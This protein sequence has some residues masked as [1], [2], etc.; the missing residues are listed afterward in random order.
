VFDDS[1]WHQATAF[2][3]NGD[4]PWGDIGL[5]VL[6]LPAPVHLRRTFTADKPVR[7]A[8]ALVSAMGICQVSINGR[9][10]GEDYFVP[11][12]TD[13]TKRIYY[14]QYDVT[15]RIRRGENVF[16]GVLADGWFSGYIGWGYRRGHYGRDIRLAVQLHLEYDDGSTA[17]IVT[18]GDWK[19]ATGPTLEADFLMGETYDARREMVGWD[20][21]GFDDSG[22]AKA[23]TGSVLKPK[24]EAYPGHTVQVF[25]EIAPVSI[26]EPVKG[27]Y[28]FD[29]GTNLAGAA[30]LKVRGKRGDT[31]VLRYAERL[32]PDGTIYTE[33]LRSA[34]ATDTYIC[35]G[36]GVEVWQPRFTFH[37]FQYVE[38]TG[39]PGVPDKDA[40]TA[41]EL[42]SATPVAGSFACSEPMLNQLYRNICQTQRA[43]FIQ[44]P[45]DCPQRDHR[46]G[47]TGDAQA[48]I[49]A[50]SYNNDV[51][52]FFTKWLVDLADSQRADGQFPQVA[53][54]KVVDDDGGPG[55]SDAGVI[56]PWTIYQVYGD[57]RLLARHYEGMKRFIAFCKNRTTEDL[58]PPAQFHCFGDWL[59]INDDTPKDVIYLSYF[60]Y[61]WFLTARTAEVLEK[62][63]E[64][65]YYD[66][67]FERI[68]AAFN[69][70]YV[71]EDG[72]IKGDSQTCMCWPWRMTCSMA[73]ENNRPPSI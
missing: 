64:A 69:K 9:A 22:W 31:I 3:D 7:R 35:K 6:K 68:K 18:D 38:V 44:I 5:S 37:G 52:A 57:R 45:T 60:A 28:V 33:N 29:M 11:G 70:A 23:A 47:W 36:D 34:R 71:A 13:Y 46:L 53:P 17:V 1:E 50:A 2:A 51:Q 65:R 62:S 72:K 19:A 39:Y 67:L 25:K 26:A 55:W 8:T 40:V 66:A 41:I 56:C 43:N 49:R 73:S 48:Y 58:L 42:T 54:L 24:I 30:R 27:V 10:V 12:W 14:M 4:R 21:P 61:S 63:E 16:G 20:K 59:N 32:N 15:D